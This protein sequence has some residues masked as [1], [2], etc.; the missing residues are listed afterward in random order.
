[1]IHPPPPTPLLPKLRTRLSLHPKLERWSKQSPLPNKHH[2]LAA[3][4]PHAQS[5]EPPLKK[6]R[7][8]ALLVSGPMAK[9]PTNSRIQREQDVDF[10]LNMVPTIKRIGIEEAVSQA[11]HYQ[12]LMRRAAEAEDF[13]AAGKLITSSFLCLLD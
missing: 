10:I 1:M 9:F 13:E 3:Y 7:T 8:K 5:G 11:S 2:C 12:G 6:K 4:E